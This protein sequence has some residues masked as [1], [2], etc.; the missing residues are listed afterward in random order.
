MKRRGA[1]R[2]NLRKRGKMWSVVFR[3]HVVDEK[4]NLVYKG[5][6]RTV[7][8]C[9]GPEKLSRAN[10]KQKAD[11][12]V[13]EANALSA[14]P[15]QMAT[16]KQFVDAHW[17]PGHVEKK[18]AST[19]DFYKTMLS[20][21]L[22]TFGKMP[23]KEITPARA[24]AL[25]D[26]KGDS[27]L[28]SATVAHIRTALTSIFKNAI[29]KGYWTGA[30]PAEGLAISGAEARE[31]QALG[32][33]QKVTLLSELPS[34]YRP[35]VL[36]LGGTGLRIG[37]ALGLRWR[38]VN[39]TDEEVAVDGILIAKNCIAIVQSYGKFGWGPVKKQRSRR[40]IPLNKKAG[41]ALAEMRDR[42][43]DGGPEDPI[44]RGRTGKP[45]DASNVASRHL[46]PAG[47][48]A[49]VP[50]VH[51]HSFRHS[52]NGLDLPTKKAV[53]GHTSETQTLSY[54][55]QGIETTRERLES[56]Q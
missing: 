21:V 33:E 14:A 18:R 43:L 56:V 3:H 20:H 52:M 40:V 17:W 27:G 11:A 48:R 49:G 46:K 29:V 55:H 25:L 19:Q 5:T 15:R 53:L 41:A 54:T 6:T 32:K 16:L 50:W 7:G 38:F 22:P 8:P 2:G 13:A 9:I 47:K 23:L 34:R 24:Q 30:N 4:G 12:I 51:W 35:L 44:F 39:L 26:A 1:Q 42:D 36:F 10:A 37:E 31:Q 28:S 45:F